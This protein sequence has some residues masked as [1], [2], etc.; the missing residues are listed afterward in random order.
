MPAVNTPSTSFNPR[1]REGGDGPELFIP[2]TN[3]SFN[4]R[5]REGGDRLPKILSDQ[6][7]SFNPRL[8][9]GGD[10]R[11]GGVYLPTSC[12]NPRLREGGDG[13][14][15]EVIRKAL[16]SIHASA[17]E[18]TKIDF[19][20]LLTTLFQSTPPRGRRLREKSRA[21]FSSRFNPRLRE[22]GD[23]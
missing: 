17:R 14:A 16:V 13:E 2:D 7:D 6:V 15:V 11:Q 22:G 21:P 3:G 12:F 20:R 23:A 10:T 1:L 5:L 18:A 19:E 4:P 9:E 8:R